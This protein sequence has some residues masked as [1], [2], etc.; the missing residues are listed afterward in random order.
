MTALKGAVEKPPLMHY[1]GITA[2]GKPVSRE[3]IPANKW[4]R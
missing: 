4:F 1:K 2:H 3:G